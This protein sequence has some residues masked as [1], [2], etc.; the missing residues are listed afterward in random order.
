MAPRI[1]EIKLRERSDSLYLVTVSGLFWHC[2]GGIH[3]GAT[4][5]EGRAT[6]VNYS[7]FTPYI[8]YIH[9]SICM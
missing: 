5:H 4:A 8:L 6:K 1:P 9:N 2:F 7:C 3:N